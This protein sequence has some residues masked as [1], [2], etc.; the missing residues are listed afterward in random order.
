MYV[1]RLVGGE[2]VD[3]LIDTG[4]AVTLVHQRVL[5]RSQKNFKLSFVGEP[6]VSANGQPLDI[7]GK[8]ELHICVN[9]VDVVHSVLVAADVTQD[10]LLGIDF[11]SKHNS[12]IDF[13]TQTIKIKNKVVGLKG[14]SGASKGFRVSLAETVV[15]PG[16]H[17]TVLHAKLRG[18]CVV[19]VC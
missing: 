1:P 15:V 3:M 19:M 6:V 14:K 7:K 2:P 10:C 18:L 11:L 16:R 17:E 5:N 12:K 9:G 4:S 13:E 8:C